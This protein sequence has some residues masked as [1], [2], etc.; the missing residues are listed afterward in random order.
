MPL[1]NSSTLP[2]HFWLAEA[3]RRRGVGVVERSAD[4]AAERFAPTAASGARRPA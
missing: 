4:D 3:L 2:V 1:R